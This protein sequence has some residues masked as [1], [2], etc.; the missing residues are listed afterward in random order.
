M[1]KLY[2]GFKIIIAF[3]GTLDTIRCSFLKQHQRDINYGI[4][5]TQ[6]N[7]ISDTNGE[8]KTAQTH[9]TIIE[10]QITN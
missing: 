2:K 6:I 5:T 8:M 3:N 1:T 7:I 4:K 9:N 10:Y